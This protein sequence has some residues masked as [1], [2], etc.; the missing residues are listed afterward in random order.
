VQQTAE[1]L[2]TSESPRVDV[3]R[4]SRSSPISAKWVVVRDPTY[5]SFTVFSSDAV[6]AAIQRLYHT[7]ARPYLVRFVVNDTVAL[8]AE[9]FDAAAA[10]AVWWEQM[11]LQADGRCSDV[12]GMVD[13]IRAELKWSDEEALAVALAFIVPPLLI[14]E[15]CRLSCRPSG[16]HGRPPV[17]DALTLKVHNLIVGW[18]ALTHQKVSTANGAWFARAVEVSAPFLVLPLRR[19]RKSISQI[20][21]MLKAEIRKL[22]SCKI[23][24]IRPPM[25]RPAVPFNE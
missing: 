2:L 21:S 17:V 7:A 1:Q 4:S 18:E 19:G 13:A 23:E 22:T 25:N 16:T 14:F 20:R 15:H 12:K 8:E 9:G 6:I 10:K 11:Q 5:V 3:Q 24:W